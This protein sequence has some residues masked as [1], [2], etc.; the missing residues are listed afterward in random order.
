M[1]I[2]RMNGG[3][4]ETKDPA[5][6]RSRDQP[7]TP[8][9]ASTM[10]KCAAAAPAGRAYNGTRCVRRTVSAMAI[11]LA[12]VCAAQPSL[13]GDRPAIDGAM[14]IWPDAGLA[15]V[16]QTDRDDAGKFSGI[17]LTPGK[18]PTV[19]SSAEELL[20]KF[21]DIN[22][23]LKEI[24]DGNAD[25]PQIYLAS[26]PA[27]LPKLKSATRRKQVFIKTVLPLVLRA[28]AEVRVERQRLLRILDHERRTGSLSPAEQWFLTD[29]A[30]RYEVDDL[31]RDELLRRVDVIPPS[32]ALAQGAEESGWGTSRFA[33]QGN[34]VFG[35]RT[36]ASGRGIVPKERAHGARFE[37]LRFAEIFTS[38]RAYLWNL[39]THPAYAA[40]RQLRGIARAE[41]RRPD[42][43][44]LAATL[45]RYSERGQAYVHTLQTIMRINRLQQF[46][47]ARLAGR[48]RTATLE[49]ASD[50]NS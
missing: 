23:S 27:D 33:H 10:V 18:R 6:G 28:N 20:R 42:S 24:R 48:D 36:F 50:G 3:R 49:T 31:D 26:F 41:D 46:D 14:S 25:V 19:L 29:L 16:R 1:T 47:G 4:N 9:E 45:T 13:A 30:R 11:A 12:A 39:N 44:R 8:G 35:Q 34:A 5:R 17:G 43:F 15:V 38:V 32:L 2:R 40:L 7:Q 37:V 21:S 22:V